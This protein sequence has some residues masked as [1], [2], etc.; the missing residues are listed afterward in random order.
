M[1]LASTL[2]S[3]RNREREEIQRRLEAFDRALEDL[4]KAKERLTHAANLYLERLQGVR[5][6]H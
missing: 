3:G 2:L 6:D 4:R 1:P 5:H